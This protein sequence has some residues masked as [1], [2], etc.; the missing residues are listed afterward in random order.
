MRG[1][2]IPSSVVDGDVLRHGVCRDLGFSDDDRRENI[3]RAGEV[4]LTKAHAGHVVFV[5]LISPFEDAR[6]HVADRCALLGV[7]FALVYVNTPLAC[8]ER[9]DPKGLY[10]RA[11]RGELTAFTGVTSPY[12]PPVAPDLEVHT[13]IESEAQSIIHVTDL[14]TRLLAVDASFW[15]VI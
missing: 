3:R 7:P 2:G 12:Q 10:R 11:R 4:A 8:C 15:T 14:A 1:L 9:R 6:R 5:A 13:E